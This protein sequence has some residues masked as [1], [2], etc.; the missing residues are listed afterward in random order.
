MCF[1]HCRL[2]PDE[3]TIIFLSPRTDGYRRIKILAKI[4]LRLLHIVHAHVH[5]I[6]CHHEIYTLLLRI[7]FVFDD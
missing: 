4:K 6:H 2:G 5:Y 1:D 3:Q 7:I